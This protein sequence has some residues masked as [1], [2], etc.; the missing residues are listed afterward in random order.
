MFALFFSG[1]VFCFIC[2]SSTSSSLLDKWPPGWGASG[3]QCLIYTFRKDHCHPGDE[4]FPPLY[5]LQVDFP[6]SCFCSLQNTAVAHIL[7]RPCTPGNILG[8]MRFSVESPR[9]HSAWWES[10]KF[11]LPVVV[12]FKL[13]KEFQFFSSLQALSGVGFV[14]SPLL[15]PSDFSIPSFSCETSSI[16]TQVLPSMLWVP[17]SDFLA[18]RY[19]TMHFSSASNSSSKNEKCVPQSTDIQICTPEVHKTVTAH[20]L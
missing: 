8:L 13:S 18:A 16:T 5:C 1:F 20:K 17:H 15:F 2:F 3:C 14:F 19:P 9:G 7:T 12:L 4:N 10:H 11:M 6:S